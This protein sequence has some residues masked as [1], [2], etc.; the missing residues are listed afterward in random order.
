V[1]PLR[2]F[3]KRLGCL[4]AACLSGCSLLFPLEAYS[5]APAAAIDGGPMVPDPVALA[6]GGPTNETVLLRFSSTGQYAGVS[7]YYSLTTS[8]SAAAVFER[9]VVAANN[10]GIARSMLGD[11]PRPW[12]FNEVENRNRPNSSGELVVSRHGVINA[13]GDFQRTLHVA[14]YLPDGGLGN[15]LESQSLTTAVRKEPEA[16]LL[17]EVLLLIGGEVRP[18]ENEDATPTDLIE[19]ATV[20]PGPTLGTFAATTPLPL[21]VADPASTIVDG[22]LFVCGGYNNELPGDR[23]S[24]CFAS[25][26]D[27][28]GRPQPFRE[29]AELPMPLMG[30]ALFKIRGKLHLVGANNPSGPNVEA[31]VYT[32]DL[33]APGA[34]WERSLLKLPFNRYLS[35]VL[36]VV[37]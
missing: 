17:N 19:L 12:T 3:I 5:P 35:D 10:R 13:P 22:E 36:V 18:S 9:T 24:R 7:P 37:P 11:P 1:M 34:R 33:T 2:Q 29:L 6:L 25:V 4:F 23:T 15:W 26:L 28:D 31:F 14:P 27:A 16:L 8:W 30:G 21:A 32:L 20:G